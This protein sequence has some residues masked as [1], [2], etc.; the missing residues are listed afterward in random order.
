MSEKEGKK[1]TIKKNK[2]ISKDKKTITLKLDNGVEIPAKNIYKEISEPISIDDIILLLN[3]P[4]WCN[5][6]G[7]PQKC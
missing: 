2:K 4:F 1:K 5:F 7:Y 3:R 6:L